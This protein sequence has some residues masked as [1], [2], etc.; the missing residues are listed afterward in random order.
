L[1]PSAWLSTTNIKTGLSAFWGF[2]N[3]A[4]IWFTDGYFSPRAEFNPFLHTWS[5]GV[6]EQFYVIFPLLFYLWIKYGKKNSV[7]GRL[8]RWILPGLI[9]L[10]LSFA[11]FETFNDQSRAF[12]L[13]PSRFWELALGAW[14]F[15]LHFNKRCIATSKLQS[16]LLLI[17]GFCLLGVGFIYTT[18]NFFPFP[19]AI[20]PVLGTLLLICGVT[21]N[22]DKQS[23]LQIFLSTDIATYLGRISYSLYLWH[24]PIYTLFRWTV[25]FDDPKLIISAVMMT[26]SLATAS[27]HFVETPFRK[28]KSISNQKNWK[29]ILSGLTIIFVS[30]TMGTTLDKYRS[31]LSLSVTRNTYTWYP[32]EHAIGKMPVQLPETDLAGRKLFVVGDSH[33]SA[34]STMLKVISEQYS[35]QVFKYLSGGANI[36]KLLA[37]MEETLLNRQLLDHILADI[38]NRAAPNDIVFFASLRMQRLGDQWAL[39]NETDIIAIQNN[40]ASQ[41]NRQIALEQASKLIDRLNNRGINVLIDAPKPIFKCP[42]FRCSDWFNEMNPICS[43]GLYIKRDFLTEII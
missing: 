30:W 7:S 8:S 15:K 10:S 22:S 36:A 3:I 11:W 6:E 39:F 27:Y 12:Y 24:W 18:S 26:F 14:L 28:N 9:F 5:L 38:E 1:I 2:S 4:L 42:P 32:H 16:E 23:I 40:K 20:A 37:P 17:S 41:K 35:V 21:N 31:Q 43:S 33:T 29:I 13:L 25:G 19:W 34:Y